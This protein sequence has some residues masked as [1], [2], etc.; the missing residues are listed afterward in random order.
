MLAARQAGAWLTADAPGMYIRPARV[1]EAEALSDLRSR[2]KAV[3]G[4]DPNSWH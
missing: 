3:C 2:S 1:K 4:H